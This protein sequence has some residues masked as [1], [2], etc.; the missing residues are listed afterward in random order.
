MATNNQLSI[1]YTIVNRRTSSFN[2]FP[3]R[4]SDNDYIETIQEAPNEGHLAP[5]LVHI[6]FQGIEAHGVINYNHTSKQV[7]HSL[8]M[9]K[10]G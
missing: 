7:E 8:H 4:D 3:D 1:L 6:Y 2:N 10:R 5:C 9:G